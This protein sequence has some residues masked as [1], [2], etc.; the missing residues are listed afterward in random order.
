MCCRFFSASSRSVFE[1]ASD[2]TKSDV[3]LR[4]IDLLPVVGTSVEAMTAHDICDTNL[5]FDVTKLIIY[6]R[7][8]KRKFSNELVVDILNNRVMFIPRIGKWFVR[9][10]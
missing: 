10:R 5:I 7:T 4:R 1:P 9:N 6:H 3:L 2:S 8:T